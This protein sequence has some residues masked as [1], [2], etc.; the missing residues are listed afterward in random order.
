M[1]GCSHKKNQSR[2]IK[3]QIISSQTSDKSWKKHKR[4]LSTIISEKKSESHFFWPRENGQ[5]FRDCLCRKSNWIQVADADGVRWMFCDCFHLGRN[6]TELAMH[7]SDARNARD[8]MGPIEIVSVRISFSLFFVCFCVFFP[9]HYFC[10]C[11]RLSSKEIS[12]RW[13]ATCCP[14]DQNDF[15][16]DKRRTLIWKVQKRKRFHLNFMV[17]LD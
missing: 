3:F 16:P 1:R 2:N 13:D 8:A 7:A 15:F 5:V 10:R 6:D 17:G 9:L 11:V 12:W 14:V 4:V